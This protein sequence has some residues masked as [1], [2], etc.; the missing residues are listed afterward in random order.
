MS[1]KILKKYRIE[2]HEEEKSNIV[3][4]LNELDENEKLYI[5]H[6]CKK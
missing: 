4:I 1:P 3:L 6:L 5:Y 2:K